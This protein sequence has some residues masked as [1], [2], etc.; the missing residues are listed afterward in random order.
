MAQKY[1]DAYYPGT[2]ALGPNEMRLTALGTGMPNLRPSQVSPGWFLEL[3]NRD[4]F[5]F[6]MGTGTM[7]NFA[8]LNIPYDEANKAFIGHLHSDHCGDFGAWFIGGWVDGRQTT[9]H[10]YGPSGE[11]L[12]MG[13][14][15][16][17]EHQLESYKWDITSRMGH[18]PVEGKQVEVHEFDWAGK[19]QIVYQENGVTVRSFPAWHAIDGSVCY[20]LEWNGMKFVYGSDNSANDFILEYAKGADVFVHECFI[21]VE[22]L[23]KKFGFSLEN[24]VNVG[25]KIHTSPQACGRIFALTQ[26]RHA[27]AYHFFNDIETNQAVYNELRKTYDGP[28]SLAKDLRVWN[29]TPDEVVEREVVYNVDTWP[30]EAEGAKPPSELTWEPHHPMSDWL[31][32]A[33]ITWDDVDQFE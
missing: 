7:R 17:I 29:I 25:T 27:I 3:G 26:P 6:D 2:E 31:A 12:E 11:N 18:R 4:K 33:R 14:K 13:I 21:T 28:L 5:F 10:V 20:S 9:V 30:T 22:M 15:H 19:N 32:Q 23:Q 8:A 16:F 24:A 1:R